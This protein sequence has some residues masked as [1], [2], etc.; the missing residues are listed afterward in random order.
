MLSVLL[1]LKEKSAI[2]R[3][4]RGLFSFADKYTRISNPHEN[5]S[6][7]LHKELSASSSELPWNGTYHCEL[8]NNNNIL[9]QEVNKHF[10]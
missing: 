8:L 1:A 4:K 9:L 6:K 10:K 2:I 7:F 3:I 5:L